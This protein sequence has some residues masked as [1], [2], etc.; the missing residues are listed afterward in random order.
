MIWKSVIWKNPEN[1][2]IPDESQRETFNQNH[3][4]W[5]ADFETNYKSDC[6]VIPKR[7]GYDG[8]TDY[9]DFKDKLSLS[10]VAWSDVSMFENDEGYFLYA[11]V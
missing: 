10:G 3:A 2:H 6:V 5:K 8:A 7:I 4:D 1:V 11:E 9:N